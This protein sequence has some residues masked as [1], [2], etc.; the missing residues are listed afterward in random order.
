MDQ[1]GG[2]FLKDRILLHHE[3][4]T[5]PS[6]LNDVSYNFNFHRWGWHI[7]DVLVFWGLAHHQNQLKPGDECGYSLGYYSHGVLAC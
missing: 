6:I 1:I 7:L 5:M 3:N 2:F 4:K